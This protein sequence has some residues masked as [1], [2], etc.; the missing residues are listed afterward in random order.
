MTFPTAAAALDF[1]ETS[2]RNSLADQAARPD[3]RAAKHA[4]V[5]F[6]NAVLAVQ[7]AGRDAAGKASAT[8]ILDAALLGIR[9]QADFDRLTALRAFVAA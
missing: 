5:C 2:L 9:T 3:S 4:A 7:I 1:A 8:A 6:E